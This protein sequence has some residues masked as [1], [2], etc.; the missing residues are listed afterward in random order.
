MGP[1]SEPLILAFDF[2]GTKCAVGV[3]DAEGRLHRE[4][5][6]RT[7]D[8]G[9]AG[10]LVE[11]ALA[12][13]DRLA[14]TQPVAAVGVATM[15]I[16]GPDGVALA[17]NVPGW[18]TLALPGRFAERYPGKPAVFVNDVKAGWQAEMRWGAL[19]AC[20]YGG[21]LN[22]GTGVALA[23]GAQGRAWTGAHGA[24]G[25]IAYGWEPGGAGHAAGRAPLEERLGGGALDRG[26]RA[27]G[28]ASD[29]R[30]AFD[31]LEQ[32]PRL[33]PWLKSA[34]EELGWWVGQALLVLDV[35]TLAVGGG[36]AARLPVFGPWWDALWREHLPFVPT[37]VPARFGRHAALMGAVA[38][39]WEAIS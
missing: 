23:F 18:E 10:A 34:F 24:A 13:G 4:G 39:A 32:D 6:L 33:E 36:V 25:E 31:R 5:E 20:E 21:Y 35:D 37:L 19:A 26:L 27:A 9:T 16:T 17:P 14:R 29:L 30:D 8:F 2:G 1:M 3:G 28:L 12:L 38:A 7:A 22:L 15:G 11:A